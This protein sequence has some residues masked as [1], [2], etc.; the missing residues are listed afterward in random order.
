MMFL[1]VRC[2]GMARSV[3][4][5]GIA[6]RSR[7]R[8]HGRL[9]RAA[10][11]ERKKPGKIHRAGAARWQGWSDMAPTPGHAWPGRHG[12][13]GPGPARRASVRLAAQERRDV[14]VAAVAAE[15]RHLG[16]G[17]RLGGR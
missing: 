8:T 13:A 5:A 7:E 12:G 1:S 3:G 17:R 6:A 9:T 10:E 4:F 2:L 11:P 14:Q 16:L 15:V